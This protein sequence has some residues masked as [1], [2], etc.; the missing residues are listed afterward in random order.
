MRP[1]LPRLN[2]G[3][4]YAVETVVD[5]LMERLECTA[6]FEAAPYVLDDDHVP[7]A[8]GADR[9]HPSV[10]G[11]V[12]RL[13]VGGAAE[14]DGVAAFSFRTKHV[15]ADAGPVRMGTGTLRSTRTLRSGIA[16]SSAWAERKPT[17]G[18]VR[19]K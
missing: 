7:L 12:G 18:R 9:L 14:E 10:G 8:G 11:A 1:L 16:A 4:L 6:R 5:F 13:V 17:D 15:G 2:C 3:P 19:R